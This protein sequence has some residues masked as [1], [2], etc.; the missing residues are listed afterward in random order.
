MGPIKNGRC[1]Y[2]TT[3]TAKVEIW[4]GPFAVSPHKNGGCSCFKGGRQIAREA[5][6]G[7]VRESEGRSNT[8][9]TAKTVKLWN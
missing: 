2:V 4:R 6:R 3:T 1:E 5:A 7:C 9:V 8:T